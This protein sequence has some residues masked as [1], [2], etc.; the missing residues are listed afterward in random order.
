[1][2]SRQSVI[3]FIGLPCFFIMTRLQIKKDL[4]VILNEMGL[5]LT[6]LSERASFQKDLGL[7]S[8]DFA[9]LIMLFEEHFDLELPILEAERIETIQGAIDLIQ[10][11]L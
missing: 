2:C 5:P 11:K 1:M 8:L 6:A 9:E 4:F 7:D 10:N 3:Y